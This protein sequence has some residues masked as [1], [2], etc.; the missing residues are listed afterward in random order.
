MNIENNNL[1]IDL[2][3]IP[4]HVAII[5]DG[6][7]RWATKRNLK[8][9]KGHEA[10]VEALRTIIEKSDDIGIKYLT[11][12]AFSTEN[13]SRP[14]TEVN[15]LMNLL[16]VYFTKE[17]MNLHNKNV[18]IRVIGDLEGLDTKGRNAA[19]K[20]MKKTENNTGLNLVIAINYGSRD[21]IVSGI[22]K[23]SNDVLDNTINIDDINEKL[24][25]NYLYTKDI[26]DPDLLIRTSGEIR[27][28]NFLMWQ[29]AYSEMY[30]T[31][32]LWP[33]FTEKE[34]LVAINE[35]QNRSRR[36]GSI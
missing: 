19:I 21:E 24:I 26:P 12:Y 22:K 6:N 28:S 16:V 13:W 25:S 11:V 32:V 9:A 10:G 27:I 5:M 8:R 3:N 29:L 34:L 30:F 14:K 4:K 2:N 20:A 33:D 36:F 15:F 23:I 17:L 7:G 18:R 1:E 31:D 35:Y